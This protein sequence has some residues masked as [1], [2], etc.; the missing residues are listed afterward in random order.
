[1]LIVRAGDQDSKE[2]QIKNYES[3][4]IQSPHG[5]TYIVKQSYS[6]RLDGRPIIGVLEIIE[7]FWPAIYG[8][9]LRIHLSALS[10][11]TRKFLC[12]VAAGPALSASIKI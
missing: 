5:N 7:V 4:H 10:I 2:Q 6:L 1:M 8:K 3:R 12:I 9:F 11:S